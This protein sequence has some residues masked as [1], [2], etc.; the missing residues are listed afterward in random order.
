MYPALV[1]M[2]SPVGL[3]RAAGLALS[4]EEI[5]WRED[6]VLRSNSDSLQC[7]LVR[8]RL[9]HKQMELVDLEEADGAGVS[10]HLAV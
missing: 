3:Q 8:L 1:G 10:W 7:L 5:G 9:K 4:T 2:I 6:L